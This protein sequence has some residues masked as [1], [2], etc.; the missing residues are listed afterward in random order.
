MTFLITKAALAVLKSTAVFLYVKLT[1]CLENISDLIWTQK[2][3]KKFQ[4]LRKACLM[5]F[6]TDE[7]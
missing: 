1:A 3:Q 2:K 5:L 4:A 7:F 6:R